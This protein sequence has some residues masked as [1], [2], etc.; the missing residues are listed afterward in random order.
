MTG[1]EYTLRLAALAAVTFLM[2]WGGAEFIGWA[3]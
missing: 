1:R 3:V 2:G